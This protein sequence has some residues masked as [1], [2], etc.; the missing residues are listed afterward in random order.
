MWQYL[1]ENHLFARS[2]EESTLDEKREITVRRINKIIEREFVSL[3]DVNKPD[4]Q[5]YFKNPKFHLII[6]VYFGAR[7]CKCIRNSY[8]SI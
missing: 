2:Y 7:N 1:E 3:A 8:D 6:V 5:L 4:Y